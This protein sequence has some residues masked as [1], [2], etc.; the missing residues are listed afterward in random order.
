LYV[1]IW[2]DFA[3]DM[4]CG[5]AELSGPRG[6]VFAN[7]RG[8]VLGTDGLPLQS[9]GGDQSTIS[10]N[11][12]PFPKFSADSDFDADGPEANA[13]VKAYWPFIRRITPEADYRE[14]VACGVLNWR[15]LY[16]TALG[17]SSQLDAE[18]ERASAA[19]DKTE[20]DIGVREEVLDGRAQRTRADD[21]GVWPRV[22]RAGNNHPVRYLILTK[23]DPNPRQ[24]GRIVERINA[25]GTLRLYALKDWAA[26]KEADTYIR[27]LG[28]EL[29]KIT[30]DWSD[31]RRLIEGLQS[32]R[33][34]AAAKREEKYVS[35]RQYLNKVFV[36]GIITRNLRRARALILSLL[37]FWELK[38]LLRKDEQNAVLDTK[39]A[40]LY[41]VSSELE[42]Q[43][44]AI[45][46][47]FDEIGG[48]TVGGLHFRI[49]RSGF[50]VAEFRRL[51]ETLEVQNIQSWV[52][53]VQ[54]VRRGLDPA[55]E[56]IAS[57][58]SRVRA[59]RDRLQ[60][61][62]ETI[63]ASALVGQSAATR[64]NTAV[65][66]QATTSWW[67][68]WRYISPSWHFRPYTHKFSITSGR[69]RPNGV[70]TSGSWL[71]KRSN[72]AVGWEQLA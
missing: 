54:F 6:E 67:P 60:T 51:L 55:F 48:R 18:E 72:T 53:Y 23:D 41:E 14:F 58:G 19:S 47:A 62:S 65:L 27:I 8:L 28:Q 66:R 16:V 7:F 69:K 2:E 61:V 35:I 29:D 32:L 64:Y 15:A 38:Q 34:F 57:V 40:L 63:E 33:E 52:S 44:I 71:P 45:G 39:Y 21:S 70:A 17:S 24:I 68:S 59:L 26:I 25:M 22:H 56:Y 36:P 20:R 9:T 3:S 10:V 49:N 37:T 4:Q 50:H 46:A 12:K 42:T 5:L 13:V 31:K 1:S 30:R 11:P 43:L